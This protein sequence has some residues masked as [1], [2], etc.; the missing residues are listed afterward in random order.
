MIKAVVD[1]NLLV[2]AFI[3]PFSH[4]R[5]IERCWRRGEFILVTSREIVK[6]VNRVLH[7]P[8]IQVKYRLAEFDIQAFVLTL[9]HKGNCVAGE[10]ALKSAAPD[11]GDDKIISCAIEGGRG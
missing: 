8:R 2:S 1:A 7:L 11:P 5:E 4:P 6:E 9:I 3:S 10:L